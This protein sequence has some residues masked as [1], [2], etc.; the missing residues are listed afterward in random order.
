MCLLIAIY[1]GNTKE[2]GHRRV[3]RRL[4][5]AALNLQYLKIADQSEGLEMVT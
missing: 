1:I 4:W 3:N 5:E 2:G